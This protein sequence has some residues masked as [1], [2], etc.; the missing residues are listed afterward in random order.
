MCDG[1]NACETV[2]KARV[3]DSAS[4]T[5]TCV[6]H[7]MIGVIAG[8]STDMPCADKNPEVSPSSSNAENIGMHVQSP[9][10]IYCS[11]LA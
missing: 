6:A 11:S 9:F 4:C 5:H 7:R 1:W 2:E 10:P 8:E 3:G